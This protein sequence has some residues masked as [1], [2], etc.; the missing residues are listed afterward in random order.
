MLAATRIAVPRSLFSRG[1]RLKSS[2]MLAMMRCL[3]SPAL[4]SSS[5]V[6]QRRRRTAFWKLFRFRVL[7]SNHSSIFFLDVSRC[8]T[9]RASYL[10]SR[11]TPSATPWWNL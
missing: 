11:I 4:I 3:R 7:C 6:A 10:R 5:M 9:S 1:L 2:M 8:G